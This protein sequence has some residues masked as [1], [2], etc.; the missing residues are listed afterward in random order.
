MEY[1]ARRE[2]ILETAASLFA[3]QGYERTTI[4][5][6]AHG[7]G[8]SV[9]GLYYYVRGKE[10]LLFHI[11]ER[12]FSMVLDALTQEL[13]RTPDP[14]ARVRA[15]IRNHLDHFLRHVSEMKVL[16]RELD[17]LQGAH[18]AQIYALRHRYYTICRKVVSD[19]AIDTVPLRLATMGLFGMLNWI[20]MWYRPDV[21]GDADALADGM[22]RIFLDGYATPREARVR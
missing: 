19:V 20:H 11:C 14:R 22:A 10:E 9:A 12:S 5:D 8:M 2:T 1:D 17:A 21:D 6:V 15:L 4:R 13:A 16:T 3:S 7:A 18:A